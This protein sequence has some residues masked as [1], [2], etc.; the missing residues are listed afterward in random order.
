MGIFEV[1]RSYHLKEFVF[2]NEIIPFGRLGRP[3]V[4]GSVNVSQESILKF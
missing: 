3:L 1:Y 2:F 4:R